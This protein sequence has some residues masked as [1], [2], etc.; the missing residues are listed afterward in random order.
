MKIIV[1]TL[2]IFALCLGE[3][4]AQSS[5]PVFVKG[6]YFEKPL[7]EF[8]REMETANNL[9]FFYVE[10]KIRNLKVSGIFKYKTPLDD[11]L[12]QLLKGTG[13][14][15][16][17]NSEGIVLYEHNKE[18]HGARSYF[19]RLKGRVTEKSSGDPLPFVNVYIPALSK[20]AVT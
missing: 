1:L 17:K 13:I 16:Y 8:I 3:V 9:K 2:C 20:G 6:D 7:L 15:F 12:E 5:N 4:K 18:E 19:Y 14:G 10:E 11:A